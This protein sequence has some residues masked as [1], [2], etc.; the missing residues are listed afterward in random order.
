MTFERYHP[1]PMIDHH[2]RA[3][4]ALRQAY[5]RRVCRRMRRTAAKWLH[6]LKVS[7]TFRSTREAAAR[8]VHAAESL[9]T[10]GMSLAGP[11]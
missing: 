3:A 4:H 11:V 9:R 1:D 10:R 8:F 7:A 2:L 5:H 6:S